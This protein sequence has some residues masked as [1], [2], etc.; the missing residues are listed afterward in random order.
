MF[1]VSKQ[2]STFGIRTTQ[3][4]EHLI[5]VIYFT[6]VLFSRAPQYATHME[7]ITK[8]CD[9]RRLMMENYLQMQ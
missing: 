5:I 2:H 4:K 6:L 1:T 7:S 3:E 8:H 9:R